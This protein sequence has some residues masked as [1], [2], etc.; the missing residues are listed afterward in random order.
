CAGGV[1]RPLASWPGAAGSR[2]G[3]GPA[4]GAGESPARAAR[5]DG[6]RFDAEQGANVELARQRS[7]ERVLEMDSGRAA[8]ER[9]RRVQVEIEADE[10]LAHDSADRVVGL[11]GAEV[12]AR[13]GRPLHR[14]FE[15]EPRPAAAFGRDL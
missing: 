4:G 10:L 6:C 1:S 9:V 14:A 3:A 8:D 15:R 2:E 13:R 5:G 11:A 7:L 12:A